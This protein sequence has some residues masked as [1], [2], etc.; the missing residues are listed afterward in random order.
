MAKM[1]SSGN[2]TCWRGYQERGML[3]HCWLDCKLVT[4][5]EINLE[6]PQKI[7]N[8]STW[9]QSYTTL[10]NIPKRCPTMPQ[11]Q[12]FFYV[13]SGIICDSQKLEK[14]QMSLDRRMDTENVV[15]LHN[16]ILLS[17]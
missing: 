8:R 4:T 16:G 6:V 14:T 2:N 11:G 10:G 15:H 5:L 9:R 12:V 3:W 1:I 17:Y 7:G 13:H